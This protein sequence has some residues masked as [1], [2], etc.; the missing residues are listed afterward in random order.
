MSYDKVK[1]SSEKVSAPKVQKF[2]KHS[3]VLP[4]NK[5]KLKFTVTK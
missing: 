2:E 4:Q 3:P 5:Q 1:G